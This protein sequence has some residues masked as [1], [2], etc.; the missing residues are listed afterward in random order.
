MQVCG[1]GVVPQPRR[2]NVLVGECRRAHRARV[3]TMLSPRMIQFKLEMLI[4][5]RILELLFLERV[6]ITKLLDFHQ[7]FVFLI[8]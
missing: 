8:S 4:V 6:L 7:L 3:L 1:F 2:E 5:F